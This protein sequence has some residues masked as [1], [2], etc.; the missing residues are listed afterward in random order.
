MSECRVPVPACKTFGVRERCPLSDTS[1]Y[2]ECT[3]SC[4][5]PIRT[6]RTYEMSGA[7][8]GP[9]GTEVIV[10]MRRVECAGPTRHVYDEEIGSV[11]L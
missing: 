2:L 6:L 8:F 11:E 1:C 4:G 10:S 5:A 7:G 3:K 9:P